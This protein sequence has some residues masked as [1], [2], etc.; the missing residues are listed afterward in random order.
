MKKIMNKEIF[1]KKKLISLEDKKNKLF[2][3]KIIPN[4]PLETIL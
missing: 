4:I 1:I 2:T 3:A